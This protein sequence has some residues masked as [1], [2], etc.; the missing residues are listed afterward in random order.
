M[1]DIDK[2]SIEKLDVDTYATWSTKM[3]WLLIAK[4][5]WDAVINEVVNQDHDQKALAMIGLCVRDHHLSTLAQCATA[6]QAWEAL[7]RVYMARSN[8]RRLQLRRELTALKLHDGEPLTKFVARARNIRDRRR[9][10]Y[11]R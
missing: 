2:I 8:A 1:A 3:R 10:S 9:A 11:H 6:R 5:L 7:H 4:G